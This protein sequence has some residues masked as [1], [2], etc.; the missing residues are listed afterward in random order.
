MSST[1]SYRPPLIRRLLPWIYVAIFLITAPLLVFYTAG[2]RYNFKKWAVER[3]GTLI[4]DSTPDGGTVWIDGQNTQEKTPVTLQ[5]LTPGWHTVRVTK[6]GYGS[7]QEEVLIR[8][9]RVTFTDHVRLWKTGE[10][11]LISA[12]TYVRLENDPNRERLLAF[13]EGEA[14]VRLGWWSPSASASTF[15]FPTTSTKELNLRWRSDG[16]AALLGGTATTPNSWYVKA[17]RDTTTAELLPP[18]RYHWSGTELIGVD[19]QSTLTVDPQT[20]RI[21]RSPLNAPALERS[22]S[23]E[24]QNTTSSE[25]LLLSDS[26]FLGRLFALPRGNWSIYAWHRPYLFLSD[27][28][29]WLGIRLRLGS[30]PD[31]LRAEGDYP[32]WSPDSKVPRAAFLNEHEISLWSPERA[33]TVIWRQ[34]TP[35]QNIVWNEEGNVLYVADATRVFALALDGEQ[36]IQ[37]AELGRFDQVWDVAV[38]GRDIFAVAKRGEER[39]IFKLPGL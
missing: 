27:E 29:R 20:G 25:Q 23:I 18:G 34:S 22:G 2:Y 4:V 31:A 35:I 14:G 36:S 21:E 13:Q 6:D 8:T 37:A 3:N 19:Q 5:Q 15:L 9:E 30:T 11:T 26:S 16:E 7:W 17:T 32:R 28:T 38:Q 12:G 10:P 24:I 39:G 1:H 33:A